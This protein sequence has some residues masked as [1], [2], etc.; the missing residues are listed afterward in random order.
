MANLI[1]H[2]VTLARRGENPY[3]ITRMPSGWLVIGDVQPLP[4]Y[5]LLLADPVVESLNALSAADRARYASDVA[6]IGDALLAVTGAYRINYETLGNLEPALHTHITPRY[7]HEPRFKRRLPRG[8]AYPRFLARR[9]DAER[10]QPFI[11]AMREAL[12]SP[13]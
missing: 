5:C 7:V 6:T 9:F 12:T 3:V 11:T 13:A 10:D 4:G 8:L 2:R 1:Q